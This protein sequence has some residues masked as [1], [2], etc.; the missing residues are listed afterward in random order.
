MKIS[1]LKR[2]KKSVL[3]SIYQEAALKRKNL[4]D[5]P[6]K[7]N[8][9]IWDDA[10][11]YSL[12]SNV[13]NLH[14]TLLVLQSRNVSAVSTHHF[15]EVSFAKFYHCNEPYLGCCISNW[16]VHSSCFFSIEYCPLNWNNWLYWG[17]IVNSKKQ[18]CSKKS[19]HNQ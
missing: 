13:W 1:L 9:E 5:C 18:A 7:I 8:H 16:R 4:T 19:S 3:K 11:Y 17:C 10:K 14:K 6:F 12:H 15:K 2:R